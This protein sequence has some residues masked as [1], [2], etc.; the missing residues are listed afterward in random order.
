MT[1]N[2]IA[3]LKPITS[4]VRKDVTGAKR[5]GKATWSKDSLTISR[6]KEHLNGGIARGCCPI[7]PGKSTTRLALF[8]L[9]SHKGEIPWD[10]MIGVL[11]SL[12]EEMQKYGINLIPF[13]SSGG[14]GIHAIAIWDGDQDAYSVRQLFERILNIIGFES[15]TKGIKHKQIEIFPKQ[16]SV[17][18]DGYGNY[19]ILPLAGKSLPIDSEHFEIQPKE[20]I[21]GMN[22]PVSDAV[23]HLTKP[24]KK[25]KSKRSN[26]TTELSAKLQ[27]FRELLKFINPNIGHDDWVKVGM[28]LHN[29]TNG[30][31]EGFFIWDEWSSQGDEYKPEEL[32]KKWDS[33]S[34]EKDK[35][36]T[37]GTLKY[38]IRQ[39]V[40]KKELDEFTNSPVLD[41]TDHSAIAKKLIESRFQFSDITS[42]I[43]L[44]SKWYKHQGKH[45][46]ETSDESVRAEIR[47]YL[48]KALK[49]NKQITVPEPFHPT[50]NHITSVADALRGIVLKEDIT[51]P[52]WL[53][54]ETKLKA[55]EI[56]SLL[57]G[58][59][60]IPTRKLLEHTAAF[61]TLN[62]LPFDWSGAGE[63]TEW[64]KFLDTIWPDDQESK[65][66]LQEIFGYLLTADTSQQKIFMIKGPPRSGKGTIGRILK[67]LL[68]ENNVCGPTLHSL[69][70]NFGLQPLLGKLAAIIP[71]A[72]ISGRADKQAITE[73]LLAIS[74]EDNL[75]VDIKYSS[76]VTTRIPARFIILTNETPQLGDASN[77]L[78]NRF[79]VLSMKQ[80]FIGKEDIG[81]EKRLLKELPQIFHW[82][83]NGKDRLIERGHFIQP[84]AAKETVEELWALNNP[85]SVFINDA[86]ELGENYEID[87]D[88]MYLT[89]K[90]WNMTV[91][92][93]FARTKD[94]FSRDLLSAESLIRAAK[95]TPKNGRH[96]VF[97]GIRLNKLWK[98]KMSDMSG[99]FSTICEKEK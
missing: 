9:D 58:L 88:E 55:E 26:I 78:S 39:E 91:G 24:S 50:V 80:S 63:P 60:H 96:P 40:I 79:I 84:T 85:I 73:K 65:E 18:L 20:Y 34:N 36:V 7:E 72:R 1:D 25:T 21:L 57:N 90:E 16:D 8:D 43:R 42:I 74:G 69:S 51:P 87:K 82:A 67:G 17:P 47:K 61:F 6:M 71:D 27:E 52:S 95:A 29:E 44:N 77:A 30:S 93:D 66:T 68:G 70:G 75:T 83:L 38:L 33:F 28:A 12:Y 97:K 13:R 56:V 37:I 32:R 5:N 99:V 54:N 4:R 3:A 22:W 11:K 62:T 64:L 76:P 98:D 89:Y 15:G 49:I 94:V 53:N 92:R 81:L 23:P 14:N 2:L 46:C 86:C 31:I 19:F 45:Y 10:E 48:D 41:S 35:V 59:L